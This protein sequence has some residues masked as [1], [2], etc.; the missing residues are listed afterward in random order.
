MKINFRSQI[1]TTRLAAFIACAFIAFGL[2]TLAPRAATLTTSGGQLT[3]ATNVDLGSLGFFDVVI[4][5]GICTAIFSGCDEVSDFN[6]T[7]VTDATTAGQALLDQVFI[8]NDPSAPGGLF[9][10]DP[11]LTVG[12]SNT[13]DCISLIPYGLRISNSSVADAIR[14]GNYD[15]ITLPDFLLDNGLGRFIDFSDPVFS[16][17]TFAVFTPVS[18]I[19]VVPLPAALPLY[20]TGLAL[21][22]FIGW[23]RKQRKVT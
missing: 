13:V 23:R 14:V 10:T 17:S 6:F 7:N 16:G 5:D 2:S 1:K 9:D 8:D 18:Q 20:G 11:E 12:C 15:E 22:G 4:T 19:S 3:G 21:M